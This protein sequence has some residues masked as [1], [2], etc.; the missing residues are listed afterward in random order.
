MATP[1]DESPG[2]SVDPTGQDRDIHGH[3]S[4][5]DNDATPP[6]TSN[7]PFRSL[8][9]CV[10]RTLFLRIS[11]GQPQTMI[12]ISRDM[13]AGVE[14]SMQDLKRLK[15]T[16]V[17]NT[18]TGMF[19]FVYKNKRVYCQMGLSETIETRVYQRSR[20]DEPSITILNLTSADK[21]ELLYS[22]YATLLELLDSIED[23]GK[24]VKTFIATR[25]IN[26]QKLP[27]FQELILLPQRNRDPQRFKVTSYHEV[28]PK[29]KNFSIQKLQ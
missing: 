4:D 19:T 3:N 14:I 17:E 26:R 15:S 28:I 11:V 25:S 8:W 5:S 23:F 1:Q 9:I 27:T 21:V 20:H 24:T 6:Q 16:S 2:Q 10:D 22:Q 7:N 13:S 18:L 12:V 29:L